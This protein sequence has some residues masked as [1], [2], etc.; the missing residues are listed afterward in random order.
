MVEYLFR[1][2]FKLMLTK[3]NMNPNE[4]A[5]KLGYDRG[6]KV[7][8]LIKGK[9]KSSFEMLEKI[10]NNFVQINLQWLITGKGEMFIQEGSFMVNEPISLYN[11]GE[12]PPCN[13]CHEKDGHIRSIENTVEVQKM[14]LEAQQQTIQLLKDKIDELTKPGEQKRK[15]G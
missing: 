2:R 14:A 13:L 5:K 6:E 9:F 3:L 11:K 1:E 10:A 4:F 8:N 7:Y 15:A 12:S